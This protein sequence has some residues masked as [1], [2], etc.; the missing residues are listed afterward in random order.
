MKQIVDRVVLVLCF[1]AFD[2]VL[3][4]FSNQ[5]IDKVVKFLMDLAKFREEIHK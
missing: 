5:L 4:I 1:R 3:K 2:C